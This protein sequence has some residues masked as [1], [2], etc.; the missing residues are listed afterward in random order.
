MK[1]KC[2]VFVLFLLLFGCTEAVKYHHT[3]GKIYGTF[4]QVSYVSSKDLQQEIRQEMEKV[5]LSL[6]MFNPQSVM[7]KLNRNE[8]REVDSLFLKM[9]Y[10]AKEVYQQTEGGYDI[11]V[12][13]L[14]HAWGFG[15]EERS[16][17]DSTKIDSLLLLV[18]MD[19]LEIVDNELIKKHSEMKLDASSIAKGLGVDL[20]AEYFDRQGVEHYM[21]E[22]GG[23]VRVK[24]KSAKNRSWR[25]GID[26]PEEEMGNG[27]TRNL[28]MVLGLTSGALATSG[29]YRNFYVHKGKKY[30][31]TINP[32]SGYPVQTEILSAS[33]YASSC[34]K[35]DAYATG[36]M[37]VGLEKAKEIISNQSDLEGC[38]IYEVNGKL[39]VWM[40]EGFKQLIAS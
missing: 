33:V 26:R 35:A 28:E 29:N 10:M 18:G 3:E 15:T 20:V 11:T 19:K 21:I 25:I 36:F 4:Y 6:S 12:A 23:E 7:A 40:S 17:P 38:L 13:P 32:K 2:G 16:F 1:N 34:M 37:V 27:A 24:G 22:I 30:A 31:H 8:S 9:F 5:N 14:V 39:E